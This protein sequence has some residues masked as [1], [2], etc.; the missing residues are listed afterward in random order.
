M[1]S[2]RKE[3]KKKKEKK[4]ASSNPGETLLTGAQSVASKTVGVGVVG[5]WDVEPSQCACLRDQRLG[6]CHSTVPSEQTAARASLPHSAG[7]ERSPP[8]AVLVRTDA[9]RGTH[10]SPP[11][12]TRPDGRRCSAPAR[13]R[14]ASCSC[15]FSLCRVP[16]AKGE[17]QRDSPAP[18]RCTA[19]RARG[20]AA[21]AAR[22]GRQSSAAR[23]T[24]KSQAH[25]RAAT[26]TDTGRRA[27][28]GRGRTG[29]CC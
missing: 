23:S 1:V 3:K 28:R 21:G 22:C 29:C 8:A 25:T 11:P 17:R 13:I 27:G 20:Q 12:S 4:K 9:A 19:G 5:Q 16:Q 14:R 10:T 15:S 18:H 26:D 2:H 6:V 24:Q 7:A